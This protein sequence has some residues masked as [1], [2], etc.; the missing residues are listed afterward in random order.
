MDINDD[1]LDWGAYNAPLKYEFRLSNFAKFSEK[2][3]K[4][5]P[6]TFFFLNEKTEQADMLQGKLNDIHASFYCC[7]MKYLWGAWL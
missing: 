3:I 7:N 1:N 6:K 2:N 4:Q 5:F